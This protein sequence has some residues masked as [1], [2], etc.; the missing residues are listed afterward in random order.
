MFKLIFFLIGLGVALIFAG[1]NA[2]NTS[3]ISFGFAVIRDVPVFLSTMTAFLAGAVF[4]LPFAFY[5]SLN[6]K[7]TAKKKKSRNEEILLAAEPQP[8]EAAGAGADDSALL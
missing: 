1:V 3:D 6:K 5:I 2:T 4:T 8:A 7:R